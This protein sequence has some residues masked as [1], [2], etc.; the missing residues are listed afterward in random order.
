MSSNLEAIVQGIAAQLR[1]VTDLKGVYTYIPD[2]PGTL[3]MIYLDVESARYPN[4][5]AWGAMTIDWGI[6]GYLVVAPR[7][8]NKEAVAALTRSLIAQIAE[9]MG[10]DMDAGGALANPGDDSRDGLMLLTE[11]TGPGYATIGGTPYQAR[12]LTFAT[13]EIFTYQYA[14]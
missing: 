7:A 1:T 14:N 8:A 12:R 10:H 6:F 4:D 13:T 2:Q 3:P 11:I 9:A 5:E